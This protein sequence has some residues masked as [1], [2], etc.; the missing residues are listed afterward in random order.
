MAPLKDVANSLTLYTGA[1]CK[2]PTRLLEIVAQLVHKRLKVLLGK[3]KYNTILIVED[4]VFR[5]QYS[6]AIQ[7]ISLAKSSECPNVTIFL[8]YFKTS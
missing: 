4:L 1:L 2:Q 3:L 8:P 6:L 7:P 5:K